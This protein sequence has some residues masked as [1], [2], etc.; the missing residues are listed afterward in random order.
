MSAEAQ[1]FWQLPGPT[2]CNKS[3]SLAAC[4][5]ALNSLKAPVQLGV[6]RLADWQHEQGKC[7]K[8]EALATSPV[9]HGCPKIALPGKRRSGAGEGLGPEV[10][11]LESYLRLT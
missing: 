4:I 8:V 11:F 3:E 10:L 1:L 2:K 9:L 6:V 7:G 5:S